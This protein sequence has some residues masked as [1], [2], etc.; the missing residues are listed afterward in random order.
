MKKKTDS[1]ITTSKLGLWALYSLISAL[2][3]WIELRER[4][5]GPG[6]IIRTSASSVSAHHVVSS[7]L[8]LRL[9]QHHHPSS[10]THRSLLVFVSALEEPE[11]LLD[12]AEWDRRSTSDGFI[13]VNVAPYLRGVS[14]VSV[15]LG[16]SSAYAGTG[17]DD[18]SVDAAGH[19]V[20]VLDI[21][22]GQVEVLLVIGGVLLN[23]S[24]GGAINHLSHL[25]TLDGLVLGHAA[26]AVHAPDNVRMTLV[27]LP[28]SVVPSL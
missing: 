16:S 28:S 24:S 13:G 17:A 3:I 10:H 6:V 19:A 9:G 5:S 1:N 7:T 2:R 18:T 21:D 14:L 15:S 27:L 8:C 20:I 12:V 22:L 25:E 26:R 23:I 11:L 4:G